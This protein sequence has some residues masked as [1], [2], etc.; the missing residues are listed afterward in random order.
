MEWYSEDLK[1]VKDASDFNSDG[2][3]LEI[4]EIYD[5]RCFIEVCK[6]NLSRKQNLCSASS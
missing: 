5:S 4:V 6:V 2:R 3:L 1:V